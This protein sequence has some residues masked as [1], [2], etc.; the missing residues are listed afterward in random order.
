MVADRAIRRRL[1]K[2][3]A[4][5]GT[6]VRSIEVTCPDPAEHARRLRGRPGNWNQ[7]VA[8]MAKSYQPS[9][10]ALVIDSCTGPGEMVN[11]AVQFVCRDG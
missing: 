11:Q 8:H 2:L 3:A 10:T 7:I 4:E 1:E 5:H 6:P 9:P